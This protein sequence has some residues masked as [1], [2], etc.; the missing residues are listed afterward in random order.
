MTRYEIYLETGTDSQPT[1]L[2]RAS[3]LSD[4][5]TEITAFRNFQNKDGKFKMAKVKDSSFC[6]QVVYEERLK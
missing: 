6:F 3:H 5:I 1:L 4:A 2:G